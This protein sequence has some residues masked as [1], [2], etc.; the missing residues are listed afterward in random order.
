MNSY[1]FRGKHGYSTPFVV[2]L[3]STQKYLFFAPF[4]ILNAVLKVITR[5]YFCTNTL[6][7]MT[8]MFA[9][10]SILGTIGYLFL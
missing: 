1:V 3:I 6:F 7:L 8:V 10:N 4:F 2:P 9:T 5:P